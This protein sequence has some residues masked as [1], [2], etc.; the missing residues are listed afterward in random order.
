MS[1]QT[2]VSKTNSGAPGVSNDNTQGFVIGSQ[3]VDTLA[4]PRVNYV[5]TDASTGAAVWV[6][7]QPI[8]SSGFANG[9]YGNGGDGA[10]TVLTGNTYTQTT[11]RQFTTLTLQGTAIFKP[12]GYPTRVSGTFSIA[13][14]A[15][16]N[17][18]GP[19]ASGATQ[20]SGLGA[21]GYLDGQSGAGGA[22]WSVSVVNAANGNSGGAAASSVYNDSQV[23]PNG[24]AGGAS[25]S[26]AA[27]PAGVATARGLGAKLQ[28]C[29]AT[30]WSPYGQLKG[31]AGGGGGA[32]TVTVG[33][34]TVAGGG[35]AGG[36]FVCIYARII[37]GD[38]RI[39]ANGGG[40]GNASAVDPV[41]NNAGGGGGG[42]GG[43]VIVVTNSYVTTLF[44]A[45]VYALGGTPGTGIGTGGTN[46]TIGTNGTVCL[47]NFGA[48][49]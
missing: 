46:G 33:S 32:I 12:A 1:Y 15:T 2:F 26:R 19:S 45:N 28:Q 25:S 21:R 34:A 5:C 29:W 6:P 4:S 11:E 14:G 27:G 37:S 18:D 43:C 47:I 7:L 3:W 9:L 38:G 31:G 24:G 36:G 16:Y 22:G 30:G 39:S 48:L 13:A 49:S 40:G 35:G 8:S 41:N 44:P 20:G 10:L 42:G 17:D 23:L